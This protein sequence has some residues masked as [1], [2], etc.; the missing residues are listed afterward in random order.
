MDFISF[1]DEF[2]ALDFRSMKLK[3]DHEN[4]PLWITPDGNIFVESFSPMY[5][6]AHNFLVTVAEVNISKFLFISLFLAGV[7]T[8]VCS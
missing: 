8:R 1:L 7:S 3:P 5:Q 6:A 2:G 4:R